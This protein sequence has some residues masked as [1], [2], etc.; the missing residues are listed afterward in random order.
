MNW[1]Y[2]IM[3]NIEYK[4]FCFS[5]DDKEIIKRYT[6][7]KNGFVDVFA[8]ANALGFEIINAH[9]EKIEENKYEVEIVRNIV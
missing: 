7:I 6:S 8:L 5:D 1:G 3:M 9:F 2:K 4:D